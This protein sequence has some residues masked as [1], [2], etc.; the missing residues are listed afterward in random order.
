MQ[1]F[2]ELAGLSYQIKDDLF[3][4]GTN[5]IGKPRGIDIKEKKMTLPLIYALNRATYFEKRRIISIIKN[6]NQN[7]KKVKEV[8]DFVIA[9]GGLEYAHK[10]ML[11]YKNKALAILKEFD[12]NEA[13]IALSN[14]VI[15]TTELKLNNMKPVLVVISLVV[16]LVSCGDKIVEKVEE[17]YPNDKPKIIGYFKMEGDTQVIVKEKELYE[18]GNV[19]M[20]G[21][22]KDGKRTGIWKAYYEDGTLWSEGEFVDG[23]RNGY[24]LNYYPNGKLRMEGNYKDDKQVGKWKFYNEEGILVEEVER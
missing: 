12:Q 23:K 3:D 17:T 16:F 20:K 10:A 15:Y 2:G 24:G 6:H 11:E 4:Y 21:E 8:I 5:K 18:N 19:K 14:L 22:F 7:T 1:K 13:N 9:S